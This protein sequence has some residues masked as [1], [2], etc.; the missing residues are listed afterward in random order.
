MNADRLTRDQLV[1]A[2]HSYG[3]ARSR[4][5]V[6]IELERHLLSPNGYPV[7]YHGQ[8]GVRHLLEGFIARGWK[9]YFEDEYPIAAFRDGASITLE[10]GSQYELSTAPF[11][12]AREA[13]LQ[14]AQFIAELETVIGDAAITPVALGYTPFAPMEDI[15]WVPKGRYVVM[16]EYLAK[17][18]SL[19]HAMMKGTCATQASYDFADEADCARKVQLGTLLGPLTTAMFANS[20]LSEGRLNGWNSYR[21]HIWTQTD[22]R[23]TG[24]PESAEH[25]SFERWVDYLLDV[26][27][28][29]LQI[30]GAWR[31]AEGR[32]FRHWMEQGFEGIFPTEADWDLHLTSVFPEV[33]V[34]RLIEV[35]GADCVPHD[36][37]I[38]FAAYFRGLFYDDTALD[39]ATEQARAFAAHGTTAE[40]FETA[41]RDGLAGTIGGRRMSAW[42]EDLVELAL[43]ALQRL[44]DGDDA[45]LRPLVDLIA[46]GESPAQRVIR[47]FQRDGSPGAVA[48]DNR[49][50]VANHP[51]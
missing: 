20:P 19:A 44:G 49:Y 38:A 46:G 33:R 2:F 45:T 14:A 37:A 3:C 36:L 41:C 5:L 40:R 31:P 22:P 26:P 15:P 17:T 23:R 11:T 34:K 4:W 28:M 8:R 30:D 6:G 42:A 1:A 51:S 12:T 9:P 10:P 13:G 27:M 29:F 7:P 50:S 47:A 25:F 18:G 21:G 43:G 39:R 48:R 35:R 16:R 32:S 24:F